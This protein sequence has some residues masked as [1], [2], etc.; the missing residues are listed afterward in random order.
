MDDMYHAK[1]LGFHPLDSKA[2]FG[3]ITLVS[4]KN[5]LEETEQD[6]TKD[7]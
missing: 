1:V 7:R 6:E 5:G 2:Y 4:V 3:R